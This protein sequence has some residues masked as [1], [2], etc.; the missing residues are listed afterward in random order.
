MG[1]RFSSGTVDGDVRRR[2]FVK[3]FTRLDGSILG[4]N[5]LSFFFFQFSFFISPSFYFT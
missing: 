4:V 1:G 2:C 5:V 3:G